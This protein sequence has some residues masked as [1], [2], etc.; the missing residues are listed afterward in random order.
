M[1][2]AARSP[3]AGG[4]KDRDDARTEARGQRTQLVDCPPGGS[5]AEL[6]PAAAAERHRL[7]RRA[8]RYQRFFY[9]LGALSVVCGL[10]LFIFAIARGWF[11]TRSFPLV[12]GGYCALLAVIIS[13]LHILEHLATFTA[14]DLQVPVVRVLLMVPVYAATSWLAI[15]VLPAAPYL[16]LFRDMYEA[17]AVY[18]FFVYMVTL[19]GGADEVVRWAMI[20]GTQSEGYPHPWPIS[21]CKKEWH[22][23]APVLQ[24]V[25]LGVIQFM[26]LKP[27]CTLIVLILSATGKYGPPRLD[28]AAGYVYCAIIYNV[29]IS[30]AFLAL[31][32]F[33]VGTKSH[34][35]VHRPLLKFACIKGVVFLS[36]WQNFLID[37]CHF[38]GVLPRISDWERGDQTRTGLQDFLICCEMLFFAVAHKFVFSASEYVDRLHGAG[39]A[40]R[41]VRSAFKRVLRH[42]NLWRELRDAWQVGG[43]FDCGGLDARDRSG[44]TPA[45]ARHGA[46]RPVQEV[47]I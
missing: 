44:G 16:D 3:H 38:A 29:S 39:T 26:V 20:E 7:V 41:G 15:L 9:A 24:R 10:S 18:M 46:A 27:V 40:P 14:P 23:T 30:T 6:D 47:V 37:I 1:P 4:D 32:Y 17:Y 12:L 28:F 11:Y 34:L 43:T 36:Y 13:S 33:Y 22:F 5:P 31:W 8:R 19:L 42:E 21:C 2:G 35:E 25:T 45:P